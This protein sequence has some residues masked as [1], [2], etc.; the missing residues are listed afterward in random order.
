MDVRRYG[1]F[2]ISG[3]DL[4]GKADL[5]TLKS[6]PLE[7]IAAAGLD[8]EEI[9]KAMAREGLT[10]VKKV[11]TR[12]GRQVETTVWVKTGGDK[13]QMAQAKDNLKNMENSPEVRAK[14]DAMYED[15][16]AKHGVEGLERH[17][18]NGSA[19]TMKDAHKIARV[20][21]SLKS[22]GHN[23]TV[24]AHEDGY[25]TVRKVLPH[26]KNGDKTPLHE[27]TLAQHMSQARAEF[28]AGSDK[29]ATRENGKREFDHEKA[30]KEHRDAVMSAYAKGKKISDNVLRDYP[31]LKKMQDE[32][33]ANKK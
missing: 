11:I 12:N 30:A 9:T 21:S 15:V 29:Y 3:F 19:V 28:A 14:K 5:N 33:E 18:M 2:N 16:Y 1:Q 26:E 20:A 31:R 13:H 25:H 24:E 23:V 8:V 4:S 7:D 10:P 17:V 27:K 22:K 6:I 32:R